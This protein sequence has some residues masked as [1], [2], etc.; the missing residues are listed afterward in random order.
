LKN[1]FFWQYCDLRIHKEAQ[2]AKGKVSHRVKEEKKISIVSLVTN[3]TAA[4]KKE[5][6]VRYEL[7]LRKA[8]K[9]KHKADA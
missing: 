3:S 8:I 6:I 2:R 1:I 9:P 7:T 5:I 4:D